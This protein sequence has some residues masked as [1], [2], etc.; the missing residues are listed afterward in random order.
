MVEYS[1][2]ILVT[3][4]FGSAVNAC[5]ERDHLTIQTASLPIVGH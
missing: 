1:I 4:S 5:P 3:D 2:R